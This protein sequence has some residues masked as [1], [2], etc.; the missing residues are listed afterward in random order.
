M[1]IFYALLFYVLIFQ[2]INGKKSNASTKD[3]NN[4]ENDIT[5]SIIEDNKSFLKDIS[6]Y[7]RELEAEQEKLTL[8]KREVNNAMNRSLGEMK[9]GSFVKNNL[10]MAINHN[11]GEST[12]NLEDEKLPL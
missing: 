12:T 7:T 10:S 11:G 3:Q 6:K 8:I 9:L 4:K 1:K 2:K 5:D